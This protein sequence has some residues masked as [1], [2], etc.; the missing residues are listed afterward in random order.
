MVKDN[1]PAKRRVYFVLKLQTIKMSYTC[2]VC[3]N[4]VC[5]LKPLL[6]TVGLNTE[7]FWKPYSMNG[8]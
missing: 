6:D 7:G 2:F 8:G 1:I 5:K 4:G 3:T